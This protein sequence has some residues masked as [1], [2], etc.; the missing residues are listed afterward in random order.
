MLIDFDPKKDRINQEKHGVTLSLARYFEWDTALTS[1]DTRR[2]YGESRMI[3]I[4]YISLRLYVVV[5]V[6]RD[7]CRRI[8]SLRKANLREVRHYAET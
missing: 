2:D 5:Y 3:A 8:I 6:N 4:G 7:D 1:A